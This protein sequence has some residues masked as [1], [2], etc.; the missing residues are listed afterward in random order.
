MFLYAEHDNVASNDIISIRVTNVAT[1]YVSNYGSMFPGD[2]A[3]FLMNGDCGLYNF[4]IIVSAGSVYSTVGI[5]TC[6]GTVLASESVCCQDG[7]I[8][9]LNNVNLSSVVGGAG[10]YEVFLH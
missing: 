9:D 2:P 8:V 7:I 10:C 1:G 5:R 6:G 3:M 4:R